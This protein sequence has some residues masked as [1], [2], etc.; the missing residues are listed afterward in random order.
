MDARG[1]RLAALGGLAALIVLVAVLIAGADD[2][3]RPPSPASDQAPAGVAPAPTEP[4]STIADPPDPGAA[5]PAPGLPPDSTSQGVV[6][7]EPAPAPP[8]EDG[9]GSGSG[10]VSP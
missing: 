9:G 5:P 4:A 7:P 6:T 2:G 1:R 3:D 8:V 10:G